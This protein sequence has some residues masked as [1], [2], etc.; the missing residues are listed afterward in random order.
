MCYVVFDSFHTIVLDGHSVKE[1]RAAFAEARTVKDKPTAIVMKTLKGKGIEGIEDMENW[2][3]KPLGDK[4]EA[5]IRG[6]TTFALLC[7]SEQHDEP[8]S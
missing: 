6:L 4:A 3:G 1:L 5:A 2:H 7:K 8:Y